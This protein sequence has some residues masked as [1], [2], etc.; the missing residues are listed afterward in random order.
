[1]V[2]CKRY[3]SPDEVEDFFGN[4]VEVGDVIFLSQYGHI[5][6]HKILGKTRKSFI[7]SSYTYKSDGSY[8]TEAERFERYEKGCKDIDMHNSKKYLYKIYRNSIVVLR[9]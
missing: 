6:I 3:N 1:V 2:N 5:N 9:K 4:K 7:I 8:C